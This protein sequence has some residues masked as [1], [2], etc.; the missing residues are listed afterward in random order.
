MSDSFDPYYKW[1]GIP[2]TEQPANHY[3]MLG[4]PPFESDLDV[5][6]NAADQRMAHVRK[7]QAG[8]NGALS[9]KV[10]N[11]LS[12]V[13]VCLLNPEKKA[14]YDA[15]LKLERNGPVATPAPARE[16]RPA[17]P[18]QPVT[19]AAA[20]KPPITNLSLP[21]AA[22]LQQPFAPASHLRPM[23]PAST[24][25]AAQ[26]TPVAHTTPVAQ[27]PKWIL[28]TAI[29]AGSALVLIAVVAFVAMVLSGS[30]D[31]ETAAKNGKQPVQSIATVDRQNDKNEAD[32]TDSDK[33]E[34][35]GQNAPE[36]TPDRT[37][38]TSQASSFRPPS[39]DELSPYGVKIL[40]G[41]YVLL[42]AMIG[43]DRECTVE[44][45]HRAAP[46]HGPQAVVGASGK[47][48][49]D[50]RSLGW[51]IATVPSGAARQFVML[52]DQPEKRTIRVQTELEPDVFQRWHHLAICKSP[53]GLT[54]FLN[55]QPLITRPQTSSSGTSVPQ[56]IGVGTDPRLRAFVYSRSGE[57]W[58]RGL[59]VSTNAR[60]D[61]PFDP[62][63]KLEADA[64]TVALRDFTQPE[65]RQIS[66]VK[67][68]HNAELVGARWVK[69]DG[70]LV[71]I[72]GQLP[73][74]EVGKTWESSSPAYG[75]LRKTETGW[76]R[77]SDG[78]IEDEYT[79]LDRTEDYVE[80]F[81]RSR[82][83]R[84]RIYDDE[85]RSWQVPAQSW[86][87]VL[88]GRWKVS[89][90]AVARRPDPSDD[91]PLETSTTHSDAAPIDE[92]PVA[93]TKLE[94]PGKDEQAAALAEIKGLFR[95]K[96]QQAKSDD[97]VKVSLAN[98]LLE[99]A[100]DSDVKPVTQF[101]LLS[102]AQDLALGGGEIDMA[103]EIAD[104]IAATFEVDV[105][106]RH[107]AL[108]ESARTEA[109]ASA[110]REALIRHILDK[111]DRFIDEGRFDLAGKSLDT[112]NSLAARVSVDKDLRI[113]VRDRRKEVGELKVFWEKAE[114]A[115]NKLEENTDDAQAHLDLGLYECFVRGNW[116]VGLGHFSKCSSPSLKAAAVKD[117]ANPQDAKLQ[118]AVGNVWWDLSQNQEGHIKD[119]L[120]LRA[121]HWYEKALPEASTIAKLRL[122]ERLK[123]T[124]EL[125]KSSVVVK[126]TRP[127]GPITPQGSA[128]M[129]GLVGYI[130]NNGQ[131]LPVIAYYESGGVFM[132]QPVHEWLR[133]RNM[134]SNT[135]SSVINL[136]GILT[137]DKATEVSIYNYARALGSSC[138]VQLRIDGKFV[139]QVGGGQPET[140]SIKLTLSKGRHTVGW[141]VKDAMPN[142]VLDLKDE[143][144]NRLTVYHDKQLLQQLGA[145]TVQ[146][147]LVLGQAVDMKATAKM[148]GLFQQAGGEVRITEFTAMG[149]QAKSIK[150]VSEIT[151]PYF[152]ID[153]MYIADPSRSQINDQFFRIFQG[154][155]PIQHLRLQRTSVTAKGLANLAGLSILRTLDLANSPG[156]TAEGFSNLGTLRS[157]QNL[158]L[159]DTAVNDKIV[160]YLKQFPMLRGL[161]LKGTGIT[162]KGIAALHELPCLHSLE[163]GSPT[164]DDAA[165]QALTQL[166]RLES[167]F[168]Y[169]TS[170]SDQAFQSVSQCPNLKWLHLIDVKIGSATSLKHLA[171]AKVLD[172]LHFRGT[173]ITNACLEQVAKIP[174]LG[175][176]FVDHNPAVTDA[177]LALL[178]D[179]KQLRNLSL[180]YTSVTPAGADALKKSLPNTKIYLD[181]K[182]H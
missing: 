166:P 102:E 90:A 2:P 34:N 36:G 107:A 168:I 21:Q 101:V 62:P 165:F 60:Y 146:D 67:R 39:P 92:T 130:S 96:F 40:E 26:S 171:N 124:E 121:R 81:S 163:I 129:R 45:W 151:S 64:S 46:T 22:S 141:L 61:A 110:Q 99:I 98:E 177:G 80:L 140:A 169:D 120:L 38:V 116:D 18:Q 106:A 160:P 57:R 182:S 115:K 131:R 122:K 175:T 72:D 42:P 8:K 137:L 147:R 70:S 142:G 73:P 138:S 126:E 180:H 19:P 20:N 41:G 170:M 27:K 1:L 133:G 93:E 167:L 28:P 113:A 3:R 86:E 152:I 31:Q 143:E 43:L 155:F 136:Q 33:A 103:F 158:R 83:H 134:S 144:G 68:K 9:Q 50:S 181:G 53:S 69:S 12:S 149:R 118:I 24:T 117:L 88:P 76:Q 104:Q 139:S 105:L 59:R 7:F 119:S 128:D 25:P 74:V 44:L 154:S 75:L 35:T 51:Q 6:E 156:I 47:A 109:R 100:S 150:N 85:I 4:L 71:Q 54:V 164:L 179:A 89:N 172:D 114:A 48:P 127:A 91:I 16:T 84:F 95:E 145:G 123:A 13:R 30:S 55:G 108:I 87:K 148:I 97:K 82:S 178:K 77:Y 15:K 153:S 176:L 111:L 162:A 49:G 157:L 37:T 29:S 173:P 66:D 14:A 10:L 11:E 94:V 159:S 52:Y 32:N 63:E 23:T 5:I 125:A 79:E 112:A 174:T 78:K 132:R 56:R 65:A 135:T 161:Q 17:T 58:I